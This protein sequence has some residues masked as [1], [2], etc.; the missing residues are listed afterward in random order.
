MPGTPSFSLYRL[1]D[2][3]TRAEVLAEF[4]AFPTRLAALV[5]AATSAA[6]ERPA[7]A[8]EWS[9]LQVLCHLRDA[10]LVY[11]LRFRFIAL[12]PETFMPNT[13][14]ERWVREGRETVAD[15]PAML[16]TI[17][18]S[19]SDIARL[20][21]RLDDAVWTRSGHH[22]V[23]GPVVLEEYVRHQVVHERAHLA[24]LQAA[25]EIPA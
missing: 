24:Q 3:L 17:A 14:E 7:A 25:L 4:A 16:D 11:A 22:E 1:D 19:R 2:P 15:I 13:D 18:A 10:A 21:G 8:G 9:A 5:G 6:L 23:L 20:L 12:N